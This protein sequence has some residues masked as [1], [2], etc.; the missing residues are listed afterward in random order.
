MSYPIENFLS[1]L[2]GVKERGHTQYL[3][4]C[5]AHDD[6]SPSLSIKETPD[7]T[8][9]VKCWS[10]CSVLEIVNAVGLE[11][12]DLFPQQNIPLH[13]SQK[14]RWNPRDLLKLL[15]R[16]MTITVAAAGQLSQGIDLTE[17]DKKRLYQ[18]YVR[19]SEIL[20]AAN[21]LD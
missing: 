20:E 12:K 10:G 2:D 21:V 18:S 9:L 14:P 11:L 5:P 16:E 3:S 13:K 1:K 6:R 7:G 8:L 19:V 15:N 4:R 17:Q